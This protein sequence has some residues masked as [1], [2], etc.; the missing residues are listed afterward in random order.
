MPSALLHSAVEFLKTEFREVFPNVVHMD[1]VRFRLVV[2]LEKKFNS[3]YEV[4]TCSE[5]PW[6]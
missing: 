3:E 1:R 6:L 2:T 5:C 4:L